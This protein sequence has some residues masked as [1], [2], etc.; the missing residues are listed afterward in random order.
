MTEETKKQVETPIL[1]NA[2]GLVMIIGVFALGASINELAAPV[3]NSNMRSIY[4]SIAMLS[5]PIIGAGFF[6]VMFG[7]VIRTLR[8]RQD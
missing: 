4:N 3:V 1:A 2:G 5:F 7:L 6:M 8:E